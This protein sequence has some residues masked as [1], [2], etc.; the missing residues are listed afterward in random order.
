MSQTIDHAVYRGADSDPVFG[1]KHFVYIWRADSIVMPN[2]A[3][4][5]DVKNYGYDGGQLVFNT[6]NY[7]QNVS[8]ASVQKNL[9]TYFYELLMY[10]GMP[11]GIESMKWLPE[12]NDCRIRIRLAKPY[13]SGYGNHIKTGGGLPNGYGAGYSLQTY[14]PAL[15]INNYYP[16][17]A[18][19]IDGWDPI[20]NDPEKTENDLNLVT[21]VPN[22]YYAYDSYEGNAFR[23]RNQ[24]QPYRP[25][26]G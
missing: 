7:I 4:Y 23:N 3:P 18:F 14:D 17:F 21:V 2:T 24:L 20:Q 11:M 13:D 6:L 15:D 8:N 1:G 19:S 10:V 12:G 22:P 5:K 25:R 9:N 26:Y 16:K